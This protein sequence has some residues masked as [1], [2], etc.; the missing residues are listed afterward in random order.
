MSWCK[1]RVYV[2]SYGKGEGHSHGW[3]KDV[4]EIMG[5]V[6]ERKNL[7]ERGTNKE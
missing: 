4:A 1:I 2:V 6:R 3:P 5:E 7:R